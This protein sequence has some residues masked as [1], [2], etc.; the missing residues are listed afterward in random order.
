[1]QRLFPRILNGEFDMPA[2]VSPECQDL[3][4]AMLTVDPLQRIP[5]A[6]ILQHPWMKNFDTAKE[7]AHLQKAAT[8]PLAKGWSMQTD[9]EILQLSKE[10]TRG[11]QKPISD[12]NALP[13]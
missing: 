13:Y 12:E 5:A 7:L 6:Q 1:M 11:S 10:A 2:D 8:K 4:Q 3:L 9:Q